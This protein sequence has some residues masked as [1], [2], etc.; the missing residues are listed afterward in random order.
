MEAPNPTENTKVEERAAPQSAAIQLQEPQAQPKPQPEAPKPPTDPFDVKTPPETNKAT[1]EA[2]EE[3]M[4]EMG[5]KGEWIKKPVKT[6]HIK[7]GSNIPKKFQFVK[8]NYAMIYR[9]RSFMRFAPFVA[10][11]DIESDQSWAQFNIDDFFGKDPSPWPWDWTTIKILWI[12]LDKS[13]QYCETLGG[14]GYLIKVDESS[15]GQLPMYINMTEEERRAILKNNRMVGQALLLKATLNQYEKPK[16][17]WWFW[18]IILIGIL[19]VVAIWALWQTG[20]LN[21]IGNWFQGITHGFGGFGLPP[22]PHSSV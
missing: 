14:G 13:A 1:G 17:N 15:K 4:A 20:L 6:W 22:Q 9:G 5:D 11:N 10:K 16:T 18:G 8:G 12:P 7:Y 3:M 2:A 19:A 21:Q